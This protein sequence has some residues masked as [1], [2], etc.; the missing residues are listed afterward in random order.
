METLAGN[1]V[2]ATRDSTRRQ[3]P[4][5]LIRLMMHHP[6]SAGM[7]LGPEDA[8]AY[9]FA[10][11]LRAASIERRLLAV[12]THPANEL[13]GLPRDAPGR[14]KVRAAI[15]RALGLITGTSDYLF[16]WA[17]GSAAI[18]FKAADG[19]LE[20][21]QRDFRDWCGACGVPFHVVRSAAEGLAVLRDA[22]VLAG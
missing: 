15:A 16:L 21:E 19:R 5:Y 18:E 11:D 8:A 7:R 1:P 4:G 17:G 22:G 10:Q 13:C 9:Q 12:W 3:T 14:F 2:D 6:L 20:A